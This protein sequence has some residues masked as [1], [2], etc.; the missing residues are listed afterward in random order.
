MDLGQAVSF[1]CAGVLALGARCFHHLGDQFAH[2]VGYP[3]R[4]VSPGPHVLAVLLELAA[5]SVT[6]VDLAY[7][8]LE[9]LIVSH[10]LFIYES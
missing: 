9:Q 2:L 5:L 8:I 10:G 7:R 1:Q 4:V 6:A 3:R